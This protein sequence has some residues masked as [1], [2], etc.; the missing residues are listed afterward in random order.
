MRLDD[1]QDRRDAL[2]AAWDACLVKNGARYAPDN[3][4]RS[5]AGAAA[6]QEPTGKAYRQVQ[7]PIPQPAKAA[8]MNKLPLLPVE[9]D[10][11]LNPHYR[12]NAVANVKCLRQHGIKVHLTKDTSENPNG[13]GWTYDDNAGPLPENSGT[14][15]HDC[16]LAAYGGKN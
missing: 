14:I 1:T 5:A 11:S 2:I 3:G 16:E 12:D 8:C 10:P 15:E 9:F 4:R 13:L 7:E 6:G